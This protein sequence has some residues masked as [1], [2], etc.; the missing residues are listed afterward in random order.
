M[1]RLHKW[2]MLFVEEFLK[3]SMGMEKDHRTS[4]KIIESMNN[5]QNLIDS[6]LLG[7]PFR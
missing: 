2:E 5:S 1:G 4:Q 6:P 3:H 7:L